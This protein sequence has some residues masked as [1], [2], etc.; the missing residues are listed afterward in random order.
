MDS[1]HIDCLAAVR[2]I[3]EEFFWEKDPSPFFADLGASL[4]SIRRQ[5]RTVKTQINSIR[6]TS[7]RE[8][9]TNIIARL[10]PGLRQH[11]RDL[12]SGLRRP[13]GHIRPQWDHW[14]APSPSGSRQVSTVD[15]SSCG[16]FL[17]VCRFYAQFLETINRAVAASLS[18]SVPTAT[19]LHS[20]P[21]DLRTLLHFFLHGSSPHIASTFSSPGL[22][23]LQSWAATRLDSDASQGVSPTHLS[24]R[25]QSKADMELGSLGYDDDISFNTIQLAAY[26]YNNSHNEWDMYSQAL[27]A[28]DQESQGKAAANLCVDIQRRFRTDNLNYNPRKVSQIFLDAIKSIWLTVKARESL[29]PWIRE[30]TVSGCLSSIEQAAFSF[31]V[32]LYIRLNGPNYDAIEDDADFQFSMIQS[33]GSGAEASPSRPGQTSSPP[34]PDMADFHISPVE[35]DGLPH[36]IPT[37]ATNKP[38]SILPG[39][40]PA[41]LTD[42]N[43]NTQ[44]FNISRTTLYLSDERQGPYSLPAPS[45]TTDHSL[46]GPPTEGS[47]LNVPP[48]QILGA[49]W[50]ARPNQ[51]IFELEG[52]VSMNGTISQDDSLYT[53]PPGSNAAA[54][55][56][57]YHSGY[58]TS[59]HGDSVQASTASSPSLQSTA[60][61]I[62][63]YAEHSPN[64][65]R[66][67]VHPHVLIDNADRHGLHVTTNERGH[68]PTSTIHTI[69]IFPG[70]TEILND[71]EDDHGEDSQTQFHDNIHVS[72][73]G[74]AFVPARIRIFRTASNEYHIH[75]ERMGLGIDDFN[76]ERSTEYEIVPQYAFDDGRTEGAEI[77][78]RRQGQC[79]GPVFRF[80]RAGNRQTQLQLYAFQGAFSGM[81]LG[82]EFKIKHLTITDKSGTKRSCNLPCIQYWVDNTKLDDATYLLDRLPRERISLERL[83][84]IKKDLNSSKMF[85][86]AEKSI[87]VLIVSE[88]VIL[89]S[90]RNIMRSK[91]SEKRILAA[92]GRSLR[93]REFHGGA[94]PGIPL[95]QEGMNYLDQDAGGF[96]EYT[97]IDIEFFSESSAKTFCDVF[98]EHR[99]DWEQRCAPIERFREAQRNPSYIVS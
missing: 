27:Q 69:R 45:E 22:H 18:Y 43:R 29:S 47:H 74:T 87:F 83:K 21:E 32:H 33:V 12:D 88:W 60:D 48:R 23:P 54:I 79:F 78:F 94:T 5:L 55:H 14:H 34:L 66:R 35:M 15:E 17:A 39:S 11:L 61:A 80:L 67:L 26:W 13:H 19:D 91:S 53:P 25:L 51:S 57:Y 59:S 52:G 37:I 84:V 75:Y 49:A 44:S 96:T 40:Q 16:H 20:H 71:T 31:I 95:S 90:V 4:E 2:N 28:S 24:R 1:Y 86:M 65:L 10:T 98:K 99:D 8:Q 64:Q 36:T 92:S 97:S 50:N 72:C 76:V 38:P 6:D 63:L 30:A 3:Y 89:R 70:E 82:E 46:R 73:N 62:E 77:Y 68:D 56:A 9:L 41:N 93:L 81:T 7:S 85:I 42:P 58:Q